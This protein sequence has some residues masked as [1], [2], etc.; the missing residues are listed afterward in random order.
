MGNSPS[1]PDVGAI[2]A[3][4]NRANAEAN[5]RRDEKMM[6]YQQSMMQQQKDEMQGKC[7]IVPI[8]I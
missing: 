3:Q 4:Q 6:M 7:S 5:A 2:M 8:L 1:G